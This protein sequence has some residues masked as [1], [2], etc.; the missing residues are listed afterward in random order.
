[1]ANYTQDDLR[2]DWEFKIVRSGTAAFRKPEVLNRL[3]EEEAQA[4]WVMLEK[5]DDSRIRFKRPRSARAKDAY[6][7]DGVD[8]YRTQYGTLATRQVKV[9]ILIGLIVLGLGVLFA[10]PQTD[11][12]GALSWSAAPPVI[13]ASIVLIML[14]LLL[15]IKKRR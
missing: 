1:M 4:G 12:I 7:P 10:L 3:I 5:L 2:N 9:G 8:P 15:F 14:G 13:L 6:L 11:G